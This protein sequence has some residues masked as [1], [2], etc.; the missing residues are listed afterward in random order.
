MESR[1][2]LQIAVCRAAPRGIVLFSLTTGEKRCLTA[3]PPYTDSDCTALALSPNHETITFFRSI[4]LGFDE[5]YTIDL[6]GKNLRQA[7]PR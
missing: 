7:H 2:Y 5:I 6:S 1:S 4:T 3:P